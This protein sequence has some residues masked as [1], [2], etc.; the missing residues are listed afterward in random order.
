M[1]K[2]YFLLATL[3]ILSLTS[4]MLIEKKDQQRTKPTKLPESK[5]LFHKGMITVK[6]NTGLREYGRQEGEVSFGINS[7]DEK[8]NKYEVDLLEKRF[9][10]NPQKLR[11]DLPDLSRIYRIEFPDEYSVTKVAREFSKDPNVEYAEPVPVNYTAEI[12]DDVLYDQC[13][14]LPQ[15]SA[16]SAWDIH[17]GEDGEEEVVIAI[18]DTGVD[19]DHEDLVDNIWQNMGE[20]VDSDGR[21]LEYIGGEWVFDPDDV[22]NFDDDGNGMVDDFIGWDFFTS[23]N[24]PNPISAFWHGTHCAGIAAG[25]TNNGV[26]IASISWNVKLLPTQVFN[27]FGLSQYAYDGIIYAAENGADVISNSWG[28]EYSQAGDDAVQYARGLGSIIVAA[29]GN[30][31]FIMPFY[32]SD[33]PGVVSVASVRDDDIKALYSS[34]GPAIDIS[35]PGGGLGLGILSTMPDG[36]YE[37]ASG[38][39]FACPMVAGCFGLLKS[40]HPDWTNEQLISQLIGTTDD[41][42]SMNPYY[43]YLLGSGRI[44]AFHMLIEENVTIPQEFKLEMVD[45]N[46]EDA[47]GNK[48]IEPGEE[49]TLDFEFRNYIPFVGEDNVTVNLETN[50]SEIIILDGT[51]TIN[52]PP[53]GFFTI[54]TPFQ[55]QVSENAS[56]HVSQLTIHFDTDLPVVYG[57]DIEIQLLVAPTGIF[58][59]E[60]EENVQDYS[61]TFIKNFLDHLGY[62]YT[63]AYDY[64]HSLKG[65]ETVFLSH[66]NV[67]EDMYKGT[68]PTVDNTMIIQEFLENGGNV[69]FELGGFFSGMQAFGYPSYNE[70]KQLFGVSSNPNVGTE[71]PID[72]LIGVGNSPFDGILFTGSNQMYN[73]YIDNLTPDTGAVIPF[74][75]NDYGNVS[76]MNYGSATFGHKVFYLSYSMAELIDRDAMSSRNNVLLKIMEFFEYELPEGYILSNFLSDKKGGEAPLEVQ[77]TDISISDSA[78]QITSWEWDFNNDGTIDANAQNP[79]WTY[80]VHGTFDIILITSNGIKTDTLVVED[81][82]SVNDGYLVYEGV[83]DGNGYS[84]I[85]IKDY[86]EDIVCSITYKNV[87]PVSLDGFEAVFLSF[88]NYGSGNIVINDQIANILIQYL[89]DGGYVY[90][91]GGNALGNDQAENTVLLDLFGLASAEDGTTNYIDSL[92]GQPDAITSDIIFSSSS[93]LTN[94]YIDIYE[95]AEG[96]IAAFEESDYGTVAVQ[97]TGDFDQRTFCFSYAL[98]DLDDGE[99]PNS[100]EELSRRI[101]VFFDIFDPIANFTADTTVVV[102]GDTVT[103]TDLSE[104]TPTSWEWEFEGGTPATSNEQNPV[105]V[106]NTPGIYMVTLIVYNDF[107]SDTLSIPGYISVG[108]VGINPLN[109]FDINIYP[110]PVNEISNIKYQISNTKYITI[111]VFD[112]HGKQI[113]TLVDENQNAGEYTVQFDGSDLPYGIYLIRLQAGMVVETTKLVVI[114]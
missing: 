35:A 101:C 67:G 36:N 9:R 4:M 27:P 70:L 17:K 96:A 83:Q 63:Y 28:G 113:R 73:W 33:Y 41:I 6:V 112:I 34:Y 75:E 53:D 91:E 46:L 11:A 42:N 47:N 62:E 97:N 79:S 100:R 59:F 98:A 50:D 90:L 61:G 110:N 14:H 107:G 13:Q 30:S 1:K 78:H 71:N 45:F 89:E 55:I 38:T 104:N 54:E 21:T 111:S 29:A 102:E 43:Q 74:Y 48:I 93:Q 92:G 39:S 24:D 65:F 58:I 99:H 49:V 81:Y 19:W 23:G 8:V 37:S 10:Y 69:Y 15:I 64:P 76:I 60:G 57:Q 20:D 22:N 25:T 82:I 3:L 7:L 103:F 88:G 108:G 51:T 109:S 80:N 106:Y 77:F 40:Y 72:S 66:G 105:I 5:Q 84:G 86:L 52:I 26:G 94:T 95:P 114:R 31:F 18:I 12:P 32:P 68:I 87:L 44:N 16:D 2:L 85:F 56:S